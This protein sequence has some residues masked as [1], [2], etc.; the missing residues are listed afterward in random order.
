MVYGGAAG[1][2][3]TFAILM[4][5]LRH[6]LTVRDFG[7]VIFRR[8]YPEITVKGAMWDTSKKIYHL[9]GGTPRENDLDWTF[10]PYGNSI[11]FAH[12]EYEKDVHKYQGAQM[13]LIGFDEL[14]TFTEYQFFYLLSRNRSTCGI[15][16]YVRATCNPDPDSWVKNFI[17]W[18]L[19]AE[20]KYADPAKAGVLRWF[21][22]QNDE[23]IW[24]S[25]REEL[26]E[27]YGSKALPKSVTFIPAKLE[28]NKILMES[29]PG[30]EA[31]LNALALVEREQLKHGDWSIR[32]Q[33]GNLY[34]RIDL[35]IVDVAP[36]CIRKVR[37]W[38]LAATKEDI[39]KKKNPDYTV[40]VL[41]G[42]NNG[43]FYVLDVVRLQDDEAIVEETIKA[44]A[45][46]DGR[47]VDIGMEQEGGSSGKIVIGHYARN[48]LQGY[49]FR[50]DR[51][52]GDKV[53][54]S[55]P[56]YTASQNRLI[57]VLRAPWNMAFINELVAFQTKGVH[58]DQADALS[59]AYEML[60]NGGA[61]PGILLL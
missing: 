33:A 49:T 24:A 14:T 10:K 60:T 50:G 35:E 30:Y 55:K 2:G 25:S 27:K 17:R 20:G 13:P 34:R 9:V 3:K 44:T 41:L 19:D 58:D 15:K 1:G 47:S 28:D 29:D 52:A 48:V 54:R 5:A 61:V 53:I 8:T 12:L 26:I 23:L 32:A 59:G 39:G 36:P 31:N 4:E 21:T 51:P 37:F 42:V 43:I 57:K 18:W 7:A 40:G 38:D 6:I 22:R 56:C 45:A 11:S 16:P 46:M